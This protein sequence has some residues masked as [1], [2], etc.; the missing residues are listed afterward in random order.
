VPKHRGFAAFHALAE[1]D[2]VHDAISAVHYVLDA[3][4]PGRECV[5][6]ERC[7]VTEFDLKFAG[8]PARGQAYARLPNDAGQIAWAR[9]RRMSVTTSPNMASARVS[10]PTN[11]LAL[12]SVTSPFSAP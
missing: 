10:R 5:G 1:R 3:C 4:Y 7:F 8:G 9:I 6:R 2:R 12:G 11:S